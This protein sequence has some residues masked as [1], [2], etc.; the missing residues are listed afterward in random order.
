MLVAIA[1]LYGI[2]AT[3]AVAAIGALDFIATEESG[4]VLLEAVVDD[5]QTPESLAGISITLLSFLL[6]T[7]FLG[8]S[9]VMAGHSVLHDR[10]TGTLAFLLLAPVRRFE[11]LAGKVA[12]AVGWSGLLYGVAAGASAG[13]TATFPIAGPFSQ[14][15]PPSA[16]WWLTFTIAGPLWALFIGAICTVVS[17]QVSDVRTAQQGVWLVVFFASLLCGSL[18][19]W[20]LQ[21]GLSAQLAAIGLAAMGFAMVL[22]LGTVA[23]HTRLS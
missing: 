11:L 17:A 21:S 1:V 23:P 6:V 3:L 12:G 2:V 14:A 16:A 10:Q 18:L 5:A 4:R 7:Q 13:L 8:V 19:T 15:L 22:V 20:S 9:S